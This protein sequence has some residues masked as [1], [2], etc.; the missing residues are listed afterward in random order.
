MQICDCFS[1]VAEGRR[2]RADPDHEACVEIL[3]DTSYRLVILAHCIVSFAA[4]SPLPDAEEEVRA[5]AALYD[6][7]SRRVLTGRQASEQRAVEEMQQASIIHFATHSVMDDERPMFSGLLLARSGTDDGLLEAREILELRLRARLVVLS[8]CDTAHA[9]RSSGEG[10]VGMSWAF[11]TA[12]C[13]TTVVSMWRADSKATART[14]IAF[15]RALRNGKSA[16]EALREGQLGLMKDSRY[17][18]PMYWAPFIV[19]GGPPH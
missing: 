16:P 19:V 17:E 13:P 18:H 12:G 7:S 14:M 10:L 5:I 9:T 6:R 11:L 4:W 8:A 15:H 3:R 2:F 1:D